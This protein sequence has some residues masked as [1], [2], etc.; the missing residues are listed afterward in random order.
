MSKYTVTVGIPTKNRY[1]SLALTLTS[2]A[3]QTHPPVEVIIVDDSDEPKDLRTLEGFH[4]LFALMHSKGIN[5]KVKFGLKKGQ[6]FSHQIVQD[7]AMGELVF[8]IDDDEIAEPDVIRRLVGTFSRL[9]KNQTVG[10]VAPA[11]LIPIPEPLRPGLR[12][13][14]KGIDTKPNAQWQKGTGVTEHEHLY[15]CFLYRKGIVSF[16]TTLSTVAH[17]EETI[18]THSLFKKGYKLFVDHDAE[19][20]HFRANGGGIRTFQHSPQLWESDEQI[21]RNYLNVWGYADDRKIVVLDNGLG[22][23]YAFLNILPELRE[24][25]KGKEIVIA[26]CFEGVFQDEPDVKLI[27]IAQA[28]VLFGNIDP[29][30][31]YRFM[32]SNNWT[33]GRTLVD[34]YRAL[35]LN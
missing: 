18:F 28:K 27:S 2:I 35:Y 21:F 12:N 19:V 34:A 29:Y 33:D 15:S 22:D 8:R 7:E 1:E 10:A 14:I 25:N 9:S 23:H 13:T 11:V 30:N 3:M 24:K 4:Y 5:V 20:H 31:V 26:A 16:D 32:E 6:H 17:R